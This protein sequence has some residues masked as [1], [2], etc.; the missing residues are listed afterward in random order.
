MFFALLSLFTTYS[1]L[2]SPM[3][4]LSQLEYKSLLFERY[5]LHISDLY[6]L[7]TLI[8]ENIF[9]QNIYWLIT[10]CHVR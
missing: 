2:V 6:V 3:A 8:F 4:M 10:I 5:I 9:T 7:K 1:R